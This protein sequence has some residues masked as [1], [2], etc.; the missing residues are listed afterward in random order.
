MSNDRAHWFH[1]NHIHCIINDK[2]TPFDVLNLA[3]PNLWNIVFSAEFVLKKIAFH[4]FSCYIELLWDFDNSGHPNLLWIYDAMIVMIHMSLILQN[5]VSS[6][7]Y[8]FNWICAERKLCFTSFYGTLNSYGI[9]TTL[10]AQTLKWF[11]CLLSCQTESVKHYVF[12]IMFCLFNGTLN[13]YGILTTLF[14]KTCAYVSNNDLYV[15]YPAKLN[16]R[17]IIFLTKL[18]K[19]LFHLCSRYI[20]LLRDFE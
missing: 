4:H 18:T 1:I 7:Y 15:Y 6:K 16:M 5:L 2:G 8:L 9:L 14:Y 12:K 10:F 3:K 13:S 17:N 19:I 20:E 11:S